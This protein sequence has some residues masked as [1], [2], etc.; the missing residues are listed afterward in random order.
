[1]IVHSTLLVA[2]AGCGNAD[3]DVVVYHPALSFL[4]PV[5][6]STVPAGD[7]S[8]SILVDEFVLTAPET[9]HMEPV[10]EPF[11]LRLVVPSADAHN[12]EGTP[13]G[14]CEL[15]LDGTVVTQMS[16]TQFT[17]PAV[18]AGAHT[19]S[20]ELFFADGDALDEAFDAAVITSVAFT[21]E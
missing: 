19:L 20:G 21:A 5:D 12:A 8:V 18:A 14:Y 17:L 9:A 2:L 13:A 10:S 11:L 6:A 4:A 16:A 7:V 3:T 15:S 1:M